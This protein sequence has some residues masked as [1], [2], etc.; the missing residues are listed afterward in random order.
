MSTEESEQSCALAKKIADDLFTA[1]KPIL[2]KYKEE[3]DA[4]GT[5]FAIFATA[6]IVAVC[7]LKDTYMGLF[8]PIA[9]TRD[10]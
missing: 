1:T 4:S 8:I 2:L 7:A 9:L 6:T 3:C 5:D 10:M